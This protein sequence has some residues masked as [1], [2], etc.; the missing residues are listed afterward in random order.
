MFLNYKM[1]IDEFRPIL[2]K[3]NCDFA[4]FYN[5][6]SSKYNPNMFYFSGYSGLGALALPKNKPSILIVPNME[7]EKAKKSMVK[8][9]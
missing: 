4:I 8:K 3:K 5:S 6:D 7:F 2:E 9:I 1:K